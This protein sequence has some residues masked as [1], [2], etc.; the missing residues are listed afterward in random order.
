VSLHTRHPFRSKHG[1]SS[2]RQQ[3]GAALVVGL[4]MLVILTLLA[5]TGTNTSRTELV[6]AQN[7]QFRKNASLAASGGIERAI[8]QLN[9][10][11][12]VPGA[13]PVEVVPTPLTPGGAETY[14]TSSQYVGDE[15]NLPQSS[16]NKFIGLHY[17][18]ESTGT[19]VRDAEERQRQGVMVVAA[20]SSSAGE[21]NFGQVGTGLP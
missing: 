17:E 6:M 3:R 9:T 12:A 15:V 20:A 18:I 2:P 8:G 7:E 19:S 16:A 1:L 5:L 4:I 11:P 13:A 14:A 10:V 21:Q